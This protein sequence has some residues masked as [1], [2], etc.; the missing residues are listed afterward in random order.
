MVQAALGGRA[1]SRAFLPIRKEEAAWHR[2]AWESRSPSWRL[3]TVGALHVVQGPPGTGKTW[4]ATRLIEDTLRVHPEAKILVCGKEHL[5][6]DHLV[7]EVR[8]SHEG[9]LRLSTHREGVDSTHQEAQTL[10]EGVLARGEGLAPKASR[11]LAA[12]LNSKGLAASWPTNIHRQES[13]IVGA[14]LA[15]AAM[16]RMVMEGEVFDLVVVEEAGKCYPS[17]L[18]GALAVGRNT[19]LIGDQMQLPPF[20]IDEITGN[21]QSLLHALNKTTK[22]SPEL[23]RSCARAA[24]GVFN[25]EPGEAIPDDL[26][27]RTAPF[28]Q[29][30]KLLHER[31]VGEVEASTTLYGEY[32]MFEELSNLVGDVFYDGPFDWAKGVE[33]EAHRLPRFHR[34]H[35]RLAL[36]DIPHC[37]DERSWMER[38]TS[39]GSLHNKREAEVAVRLAQTMA[40]GAQENAVVVLTPYIGQRDLIRTMLGDEGSEIEVHTVDGFQGKERDFVVLSLVRNNDKS[41]GRRWGFVRDARRLNVALSRAREGLTVVCSLKHLAGS[42]FS[43]DEMHLDRSINTISKAAYV[44]W[45]DV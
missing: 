41:A 11:R 39:T 35:G 7:A 34:D 26:V 22:G 24:R 36:V 8:D 42:S 30:F 1:A 18:A 5:A 19:V 14:T 3:P 4:T 45:E 2:A 37:S 38:R 33:V 12:S 13:R 16:E 44:S 32:R 9:K 43:D 17:E 27:Q 25:L 15:S 31:G 23:Q 20:E 28:L 21:L 40:E 10:L 6:L 29:P